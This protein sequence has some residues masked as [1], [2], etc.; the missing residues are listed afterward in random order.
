MKK[1]IISIII[2]LI[3]GILSYLTTTAYHYYANPESKTAYKIER[4]RD[5]TLR[6]AYIGDSWAYMHEKHHCQIPQIIEMQNGQPVIVYSYGLGGKTSKDIY[7]ALF[8]DSR[9]RALLTEHGCDFCVIS[10]GINDINKKMS[11]HYYQ[12]SMDYIIDFMI[13]NNIHPIIL[14]IPDVDVFKAY[15]GL[16]AISQLLRQLSMIINNI[17]MDC[18]QLYRDAL[19][20]LIREKGYKN[21]V[22]IIRYK[23][24]NTNYSYG[25][26]KLY[27]KDGIHL[28]DYGY[29][30]L[31]SVIAKEI[32]SNI[33]NHENRN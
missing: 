23:S 32:I 1:Y 22:S 16:R 17:P 13:S 20:N 5:D 14:E 9:L 3:A 19:N 10:A 27:L 30:V 29:L 31:D 24:W 4:H 2:L 18:K 28:N 6:I 7:E 15:R 26:K 11:T 21:K 12:E 33:S 25:Q 8:N